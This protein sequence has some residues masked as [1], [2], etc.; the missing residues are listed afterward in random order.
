VSDPDCKPVAGPVA[1]RELSRVESRRRAE[2]LSVADG[3]AVHKPVAGLPDLRR[4]RFAGSMPV[5]D[6]VVLTGSDAKRLSD[7]Q[8]R[9]KRAVPDTDAYSIAGPVAVAVPH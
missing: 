4:R 1:E 2:P 7:R 3:A 5:A 8:Q 6:R 9:P